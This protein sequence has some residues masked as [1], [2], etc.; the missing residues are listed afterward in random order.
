M[1]YKVLKGT[2]LEKATLDSTWPDFKRANARKL[3]LKKSNRKSRRT[4]G[5]KV[6]VWVLPMIEGDPHNYRRAKGGP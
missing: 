5:P 6:V 4:A 2:T 1:G 3:I